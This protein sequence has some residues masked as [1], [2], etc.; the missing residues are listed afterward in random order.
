MGQQRRAFARCSCMKTLA[1]A[2]ALALAGTSALA[3]AQER[4]P[5]HGGGYHGGHHHHGHGRHYGPRY[6]GYGHAR[7]YY[8]HPYV[9]GPPLYSYVPGYV[10]AYPPPPPVVLE[11]RYEIVPPPPPPPRREYQ[12]RSQAQIVPP[13]PKPA[14]APQPAQPAPMLERYTLSATELFEFDSATLRQP[15]P[16][17][18]EIAE[19]M[20]R[21]PLIDNVNVTG[22]TDRLGSESYNLKLS[23]RRAEAVKAYIASKGVE[24]LRLK[25]IGKGESSPV[26]QCDDADRE[27]LIRCLEPNRRV[28]VEQITVTRQIP[29]P[30]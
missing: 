14:P 28:E 23:Q 30:R 7:P 27:A 3:Q 6:Y 4:R 21:N 18:D 20:R 8:G 29:A 1:I 25:A 22:H 26:V 11:P 2:V 19:A 9:Y 5:K 13:P 24:P 15:Q 12:E 16:K 10:Y 17:L